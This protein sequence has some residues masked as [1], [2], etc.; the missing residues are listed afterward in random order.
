MK[1]L[2]DFSL[3]CMS[4]LQVYFL[5][6]LKFKN[7]LVDENNIPYKQNIKIKTKKK[8]KFP[9]FIVIHQLPSVKDVQDAKD[10]DSDS[11]PIYF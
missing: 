8:N 1:F 3:Y 9:K 6:N 5:L 10:I 11:K 4:I 7:K 2:I